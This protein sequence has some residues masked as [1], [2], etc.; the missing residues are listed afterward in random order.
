MVCI[1]TRS[2]NPAI[3]LAF[4]EYFLKG[5]DLGEDVFMLW[6]SE[7]AIIIGRFQNTWE[8]TNFH[9]AEN[10]NIQ[11]IRRMSGGG[12]VYHDAGNLCFSFILRNVTP[13]RFNKVAYI[14][15]IVNALGKL[16][17]KAEI[18]KRNDLFINGKK[19]SGNAMAYHKNRL[20][21]HGTLLFNT[22]LDMLEKALRKPVIQIDSKGVKSIRSRV[23]NIK[24]YLSTELDISQFKQQL[25]HLLQEN[26]SANY[27]LPTKGDL[28]SIQRLIGDKYQSWDWNFGNSPP[29]TLTNSCLIDGHRLMIILTLENGTI[30]SCKFES[31]FFKQ[32]EGI[33][34]EQRLINT[35]FLKKDILSILKDS[36]R[37]GNPEAI[38]EDELVQLIMGISP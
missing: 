37:T 36:L 20:L 26:E 12:A 28:D 9:F 35:R 8:E 16:G 22:D 4:E 38:N 6:Q 10:H 7:P 21:F 33:A 32:G 31:D 5:R 3:N 24:Q 27:Y 18:T 23:T 11:I 19:F 25:T 29:S 15:P 34:I 13:D 30:K 17:I 2:N 1:E 14:Q